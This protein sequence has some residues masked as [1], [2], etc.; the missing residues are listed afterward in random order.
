MSLARALD[1]WVECACLIAKPM[2]D[3]VDFR[4]GMF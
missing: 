2:L 4:K 1:A 3:N